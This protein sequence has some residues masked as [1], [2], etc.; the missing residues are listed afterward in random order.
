MSNLHKNNNNIDLQNEKLH[1][2]VI[3]LLMLDIDYFKFNGLTI[4]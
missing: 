1:D 4:I 2:K 3:G